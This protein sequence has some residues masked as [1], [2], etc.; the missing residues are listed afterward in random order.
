MW[1]EFDGEMKVHVNMGD[2]FHEVLGETR[3]GGCPG[4]HKVVGSLIAG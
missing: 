3:N 4:L 2:L 1:F